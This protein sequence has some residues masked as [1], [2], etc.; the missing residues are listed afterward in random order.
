MDIETELLLW[1]NLRALKDTTVLAVSHP[2]A[3]LLIADH[4]VVLHD[5]R[6][7]REDS[8]MQLTD[9]LDRFE[10]GIEESFT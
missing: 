7:I 10:R 1:K 5:G 8:P 3:A 2:S 9:W 6:I 4:I